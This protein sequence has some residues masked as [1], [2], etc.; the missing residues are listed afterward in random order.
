MAWILAA[1]SSNPLNN[2]SSDFV[3]LSCVCVCVHFA[4]YLSIYLRS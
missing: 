1:L 3:G 2:P 4:I